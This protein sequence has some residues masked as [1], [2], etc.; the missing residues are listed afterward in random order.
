MLENVIEISHKK[1][2]GGYKTVSKLALP[3]RKFGRNKWLSIV[4][5]YRKNEEGSYE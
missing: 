1:P 4:I 5:I 2:A 3:N